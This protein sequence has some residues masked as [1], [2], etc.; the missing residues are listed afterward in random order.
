[1]FDTKLNLLTCCVDL[2]PLVAARWRY[3]V[4]HWAAHSSGAQQWKSYIWHLYTMYVLYR[5]A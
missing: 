3:G 2:E 4:I 1:M 5:I